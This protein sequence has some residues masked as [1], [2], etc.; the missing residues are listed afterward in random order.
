MKLKKP[1]CLFLLCFTFSSILGSSF[2]VLPVQAQRLVRGD[3]GEYSCE[4][5]LTKLEQNWPEKTKAY[6]G[7]CTEKKTLAL[8]VWGE[9]GQRNVSFACW[10]PPNADGSADGSFLGILPYPG[11]EAEFVTSWNCSESDD[12]CEALA[13]LKTQE[14]EMFNRYNFECRT[15]GGSINL[16][17]SDSDPRAFQVQ[18]YFQAGVV[19]WDGDGDGVSDG[20]NSRG[21]GVDVI[22]GEFSLPAP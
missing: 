14:L 10:E 11:E 18:C 19:L 1:D 6:L 8:S 2:N 9:S 4:L 15:Y 20:E 22:L 3:C 13:Y 7:N 21:A 17:V 5:L 12:S 16:L